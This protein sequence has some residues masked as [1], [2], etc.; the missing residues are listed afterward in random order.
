MANIPTP[1]PAANKQLQVRLVE[2]VDKG[3]KLILLIISIS[4]FQG[5]PKEQEI[6]YFGKVNSKRTYALERH[7][8]IIRLIV[9]TEEDDKTSMFF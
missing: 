1:F 3:E 8:D 2:F 7:D 9:M 6:I 4:L 5:V